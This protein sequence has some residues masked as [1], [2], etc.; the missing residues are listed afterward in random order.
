MVLLC[1]EKK[2]H[3]SG[4]HVGIIEEREKRKVKSEK[5]KVERER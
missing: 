1:L 4:G 2:K 3:K 5:R